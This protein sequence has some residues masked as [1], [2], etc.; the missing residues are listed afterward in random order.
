MDYPPVIQRITETPR[1]STPHPEPP[2][3]SVRPRPASQ[4]QRPRASSVPPTPKPAKRMA[5]R[6]QPVTE[7]ITPPITPPR[8]QA[9]ERNIDQD[10]PS[11]VR[12]PGRSRG[13]GTWRA[14]QKIAPG[15]GTRS[16]TRQAE[17]EQLEA[18]QAQAA[19]A[20]WPPSPDTTKDIQR[21]TRELR[22]C[23]VPRDAHKEL[24]KILPS[25]DENENQ[26]L[27]QPPAAGLVTQHQDVYFIPPPRVVG[28]ARGNSAPVSTA[29]L[30]LIH[31]QDPSLAARGS[32]LHDVTIHQTA[33][34]QYDAPHQ[35]WHVGPAGFPPTMGRGD[36][37]PRRYIHIVIL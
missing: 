29:T 34:I 27:L 8:A 36:A 1:Q 9:I 23:D 3:L 22:L 14:P 37:S 18:T 17:L 19:R 28:G 5:L 12:K 30:G 15:V 21:L 2:T 20:E 16:K 6:Y 33:S 24:Q 35:D 31:R 7:E 4:L 10:T 13:R 26:T 32:R 11:P 25:L